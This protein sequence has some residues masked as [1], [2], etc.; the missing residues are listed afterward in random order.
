MCY[1]TKI[2]QVDKTVLVSCRVE[3][4]PYRLHCLQTSITSKTDTDIYSWFEGLNRMHTSSRE[5]DKLIS[6]LTRFNNNLMVYV[7][8]KELG[9]C[10]W[11]VLKKLFERISLSLKTC[12]DT[13][14][15]CILCACTMIAAGK[16]KCRTRAGWN[17][18]HSCPVTLRHWDFFYKNSSWVL[19]LLQ[20]D[21]LNK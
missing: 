10:G 17:T 18:C 9:F 19:H 20:G 4:S 1:Y 21:H 12:E 7:K 14:V 6:S 11:M 3:H 13:C 5:I 8:S 15:H 2:R 16:V